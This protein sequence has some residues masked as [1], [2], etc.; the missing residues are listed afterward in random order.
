MGASGGEKPIRRAT[1]ERLCTEI[2]DINRLKWWTRNRLWRWVCVRLAKADTS[3]LR[4]GRRADN[5][6]CSQVNRLYAGRVVG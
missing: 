1:T 6:G 2:R 3:E 4:F 5:R